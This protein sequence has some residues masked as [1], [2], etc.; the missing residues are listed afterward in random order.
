MK[1]SRGKKDAHVGLSRL[2]GWS[3]AR[4][5]I[6]TSAQEQ[7]TGKNLNRRRKQCVAYGEVGHQIDSTNDP[8]HPLEGFPSAH[9]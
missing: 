1:P 6:L 9:L 2:L 5:K 3:G 7:D 4:I 8:P